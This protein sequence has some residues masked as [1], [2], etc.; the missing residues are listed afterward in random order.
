MTERVKVFAS[1]FKKKRPFYEE[2]YWKKKEELQKLK[3]D[4]EQRGR[5]R[6]EARVSEKE[7]EI[8]DMQSRLA[9]V[10]T[11]KLEILRLLDAAQRNYELLKKEI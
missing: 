5:A 6:A 1:L 11:E 2:S 4:D 3:V 10:A 7:K 9:E 8:K